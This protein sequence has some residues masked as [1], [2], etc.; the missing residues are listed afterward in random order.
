MK[1]RTNPLLKFQGLPPTNAELRLDEIRLKKDSQIFNWFVHSSRGQETIKLVREKLGLPKD[2]SKLPSQCLPNVTLETVLE[3]HNTPK[4]NLKRLQEFTYQILRLSNNRLSDRFYNSMRDYV[5]FNTK[6]TPEP[7][8]RPQL[9]RRGKKLNKKELWI[10][11]YPEATF[12][13][14]KIAWHQIVLIQQELPQQNHK[15]RWKV[16]IAKTN[17]KKYHYEPPIID[18]HKVYAQVYKNTVLKDLDT[19]KFRKELKTKLKQAG[20]NNRNFREWN[21]KKALDLLKM[22]KVTKSDWDKAEELFG[23]ER[24]RL[25]L[26]KLRLRARNKL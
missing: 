1:K 2:G 18:K 13:D 15:N 19:P 17:E 22:D 20:L 21:Y 14:L 10:R 26:K 7:P 16:F 12:R 4:V 3:H 25:K 9:I 5:V 24:Q 8:V 11:I 23:D 6:L